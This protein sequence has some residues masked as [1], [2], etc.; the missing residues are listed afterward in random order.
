M[1]NANVPRKP[2]VLVVMDGWGFREAP[3][4]NAIALADT[5]HWDHLWQRCP[6]TLLEASGPRVGLPEYQMGNSEVGHLNI[7]AGRIVPQDIVRI[8]QAIDD[9]SFF[10]IKV[11]EQLCASVRASGGT[12]H[13]IG[14]LG[15]GGV[16]AVDRHLYAA[17][18]L[19]AGSG[20]SRIAVHAFTDGRDTPPRSGLTFMQELM[21]H[22][23]GA[24]VPVVVSTVVG[25]YYAMDR[26]R[27]W[28]RIQLAYDAMVRGVGVSM[29]D[30]VEALRSVYE[31][32]ETDEFVKP[33]V[34]SGAPRIQDGDGVFCVNFRA[35]RMRQIV[36][37]LTEEGFEG[38]DVT[39]RPDA[40]LATMTMYDETF[41]VPYAFGPVVL[42]KIMAEVVSDHD[43]SQ[44]RVAETEKYAHITYFF[45]GGFEVPYRGE[46][47]RLVPSP[48]VATYDLQPE[49]SAAGV[50]DTLCQAI[51]TKQHEFILCNYANGDMVGHSGVLPAAIKAVTTV[52]GALGQIC[53]AVDDAGA[54]LALTAD[55]GNCEMMVDPMTGGPHTAHT[56]NP[57]P[58]LLYGDERCRSLRAGGKL[59]DIA[60]T[61]LR[62]LAI[63]PPTEM[64]GDDLREGC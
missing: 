58:F 42:S 33:I 45:N 8:D 13:L 54:V 16:H 12:L 25:R 46:E 44:F 24:S 30:P 41:T 61:L 11:L 4:G 47:R 6:R 50:T 57:V 55:H 18:E 17:I 26:D 15:N 35:D 48:Q 34:L 3:D 39:P 59:G 28:S 9:A 7:G 51:R 37:A 43:M 31:R 29:T 1:S 22:A 64:S 49:M 19:G 52:D 53:R 27:R 38:F 23:R 62:L 32:D 5:P 56:T 63:D 36:R 40:T 21:E 60:P 14:L 10:A 20:V 2:V